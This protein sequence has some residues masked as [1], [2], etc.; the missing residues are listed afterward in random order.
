[1]AKVFDLYSE[2][3]VEGR[4]FQVLLIRVTTPGTVGAGAKRK[5]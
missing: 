4:N 5:A 3:I 2:W 1:M